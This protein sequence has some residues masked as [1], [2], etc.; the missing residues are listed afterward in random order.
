MDPRMGEPMINAFFGN[1]DGPHKA[2]AQKYDKKNT[3]KQL[4]FKFYKWKISAQII[5]AFYDFSKKKNGKKLK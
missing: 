4:P 3:R 1:R 2:Q 5:S